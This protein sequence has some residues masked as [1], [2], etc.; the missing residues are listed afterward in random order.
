MYSALNTL[1]RLIIIICRL[2]LLLRWCL[3]EGFLLK[4]RQSLLMYHLRKA[5][6]VQNNIGRKAS[7]V[8]CSLFFPLVWRLVLIS[9]CSIGILVI[10]VCSIRISYTL[11]M[12]VG[13]KVTHMKSSIKN[14]VW[15]LFP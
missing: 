8:H 4:Y 14:A 2:C 13:T 7:Y 12:G 3:G 6:D 9:V 1:L 5:T 11:K 10:G 15:F